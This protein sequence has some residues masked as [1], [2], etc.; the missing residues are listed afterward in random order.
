[1]K[2]VQRFFTLSAMLALSLGMLSACASS[3]YIS[4]DYRLPAVSQKLAHRTVFLEYKDERT[5]KAFLSPSAQAQFKNF[6]GIFSLILTEPQSE[7]LVG[8]FEAGP[9][10]KEAVK[11]RLS[12]LGIEAASAAAPRQGVMEIALKEFFLNLEARRWKAR[13]EFVASL[14][15][16]DGRTAS[17]TVSGEAERFKSLGHR[18]AEEVL[19]DIFTDAVNQINIV[20]LFQK[21][22][23]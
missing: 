15:A 22:G 23:L 7:H 5:P 20:E 17:Q 19:S 4:I 6:S 14:T 21:V 8:G 1:M 3:P 10:F 13:I 12:A 11:R 9:L 2:P 18:E 16:P